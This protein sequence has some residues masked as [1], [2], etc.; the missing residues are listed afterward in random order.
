[1]KDRVDGAALLHSTTGQKTKKQL[2]N[3]SSNCMSKFSSNLNSNAKIKSKVHTSGKPTT[4]TSV[5]NDSTMRKGPS[6]QL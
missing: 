3:A 4:L 2:L 1:M 5:N 6:H